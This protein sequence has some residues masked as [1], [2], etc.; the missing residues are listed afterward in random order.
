M[1]IHNECSF[2]LNTVRQRGKQKNTSQSSY[3]KTKRRCSNYIS[4]YIRCT[5]Y[6]GNRPFEFSSNFCL[7]KK[8]R[9]K[10]GEKN[11]TTMYDVV[12]FAHAVATVELAFASGVRNLSALARA[13]KA[14]IVRVASRRVAGRSAA[15]ACRLAFR[16]PSFELEGR[17]GRLCELAKPVVV[18][19]FNNKQDNTINN[20]CTTDNY[21]SCC[22]VFS[23]T[24]LY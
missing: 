14:L 23:N 15:V 4:I 6:R 13:A 22:S 3:D 8:G 18:M 12:R 5:I 17:R 2:P 20:N 11:T 16:I 19:L 21:Y 24:L 9:S 10:D 1:Y 7:A